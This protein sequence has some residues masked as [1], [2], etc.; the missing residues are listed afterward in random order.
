[1][2]YTI[3]EIKKILSSYIDETY[4][5]NGCYVDGNWLCV[6]NIIKMIERG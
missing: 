6:E 5:E 1:M 2:S 4:W 3:E